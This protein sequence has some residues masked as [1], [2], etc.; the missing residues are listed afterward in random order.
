MSPFFKAS[1]GRPAQHWYEIST[2]QLLILYLFLLLTFSYKQ[3]STQ[4]VASLTLCHVIYHT[5]TPILCLQALLIF[6]SCFSHLFPDLFD[7]YLC[8]VISICGIGCLTAVIGDVASHF[9]CTVGLKDAVTAVA[10]VALGTS[11]PGKATTASSSFQDL[12]Q[13]TLQMLCRSAMNNWDRFSIWITVYTSFLYLCAFLHS[14]LNLH[15]C[16][17]NCLSTISRVPLEIF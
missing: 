15:V 13:W 8:F 2:L 11:V 10:F 17:Y 12:L 1:E 9:G 6:S 16:F 5:F 14:L 3:T 4:H 7:G